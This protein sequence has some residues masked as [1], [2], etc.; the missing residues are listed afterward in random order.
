MTTPNRKGMTLIEMMIALTIVAGLS[1]GAVTVINSITRA[2]LKASAMRVSGYIKHTYSISAIHQQY[3]R[4]MIDLDTQ[5]YW[6][7]TAEQSDIGSP[8]QIPDSA[9]VVDAPGDL[10]YK[11]TRRS[12][13]GYDVDDPEGSALGLRR[14]TFKPSEDLLTQ[15]RKLQGATFHSVTT[16]SEQKPRLAGRTSITFFPNGFAERSQIVL[17]DGEGGASCPLRSNP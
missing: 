14:P 11:P 4:L 9:L 16:A 10:D 8:P 3:Y 17:S 7:E 12:S 5:E 6:V 13:G 2:N 15:R 1:V